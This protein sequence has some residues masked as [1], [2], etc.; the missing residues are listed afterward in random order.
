MAGAA[1]WLIEIGRCLQTTSGMEFFMSQKSESL[2]LTHFLGGNA[3]DVKKLNLKAVLWQYFE[4]TLLISG[5]QVPFC[6]A[7]KPQESTVGEGELNLGCG[8]A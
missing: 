7:L 5:Y 2:H 1:A 6:G 3:T 8:K 4:T